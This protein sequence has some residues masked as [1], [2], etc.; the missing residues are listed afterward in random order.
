MC[1]STIGLSQDDPIEVPKI[2]VRIPLGEIVQF[3]KATV[4]FIK[5]L[6]DS[7][8]PKDVTC[9]WAGRARVMAEVTENGKNPVEIELVF[10]GREKNVLFASEDYILKGI[11][12]TPYPTI[13][14]AGKMKYGLLV[15]EEIN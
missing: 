2:T 14:T 5:V 15:S 13:E 7:R 9:V 1:A 8:C 11:L 12:L 4:R 6:E 10:G 3:E